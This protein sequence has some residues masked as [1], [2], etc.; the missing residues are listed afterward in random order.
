[1]QDEVVNGLRRG[2]RMLQCGTHG[3][4]LLCRVGCHFFGS[5]RPLLRILKLLGLRLVLETAHDVDVCILWAQTAIFVSLTA[6]NC[7]LRLSRQPFSQ[8]LLSQRR[9]LN[10]G[11]G[12]HLSL[13][14]EFHFAL[15]VNW[16]LQILVL[17]DECV[18]T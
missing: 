7:Q 18:L 10:F 5:I 3:V 16:L 12:Q 1:M 11:S 2:L 6:L 14:H 17:A 13:A 15:A 9:V 8:V 4:G